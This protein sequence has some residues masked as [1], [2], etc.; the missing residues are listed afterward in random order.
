MDPEDG[1][2]K[3]VSTSESIPSGHAIASRS[4]RS[5][6]VANSKTAFLIK[7]EKTSWEQMTATVLAILGRHG[8]IVAALAK[9]EG[10]TYALMKLQRG[11]ERMH[12]LI[13]V[14]QRTGKNASVVCF[15][16][17]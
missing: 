8:K 7:I 4:N 9:R 12:T 5:V 6:A 10:K 15:G 13:T 14:M 11:P 1:T 2:V 17:I 16:E 3:E